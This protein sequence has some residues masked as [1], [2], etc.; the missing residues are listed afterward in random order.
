MSATNSPRR[1]TPRLRWLRLRPGHGRPARLSQLSGHECS[2]VLRR[3][4]S[5]GGGDAPAAS[6]PPPEQGWGTIAVVEAD[7]GWDEPT[8]P[9]TGPRNV[10]IHPVLVQLLCAWVDEHDLAPDGLLFRTTGNRRPSQSNWARALG[11][12]CATANESRIRVYD[13][14]HSAATVWIR[15]GVPLGEA[16]RRLGHSVETPRG[17]GQRRP[18]NR[19][20]DVE[21]CSRM[22]PRSED[23][24]VSGS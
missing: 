23:C 13:L 22:R 10:P 18:S 8:E 5:F 1:P 3:F 20:S 15:S 11:R 14:R 24:G 19:P 2:G 4:A 21:P 6:A 9:K 17:R 16:A 7:D 12:A